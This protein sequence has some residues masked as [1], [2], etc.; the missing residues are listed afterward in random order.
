MKDNADALFFILLFALKYR[1]YAF[2]A[3][4]EIRKGD[5]G[6][7]SF[8][9]NASEWGKNVGKAKKNKQWEVLNGIVIILMLVCV[10]VGCSVVIRQ[11]P[12]YQVPNY[13]SFGGCG[14]LS[15]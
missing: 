11:Y 2:D 15:S 4:T 14:H 12:G 6:G 13:G 5:F 1:K 9:K 7:A 8:A 3:H 10:C